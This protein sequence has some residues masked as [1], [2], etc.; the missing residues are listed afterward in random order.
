LGYTIPEWAER[1]KLVNL[2]RRDKKAMGDLTFV[3]D[4]GS[5]LEV[6]RNVEENIVV[7]V[8]KDL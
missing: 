4:G 8:L 2:M 7:D 1:E 3:L 5:G 6:V